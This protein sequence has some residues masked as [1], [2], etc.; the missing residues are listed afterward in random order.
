MQESAS[1]TEKEES[2]AAYVGRAWNR[3]FWL[4]IFFGVAGLIVFFSLIWVGK[5]EME[6]AKDAVVEIA[7]SYTHLTLPTKVTV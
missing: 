5:Q 6:S 4:F 7:V 1:E 3:L 2:Q